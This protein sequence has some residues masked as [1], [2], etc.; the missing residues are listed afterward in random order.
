MEVEYCLTK[1]LGVNKNLLPVIR[2]I[3]VRKNARFKDIKN[4]FR[5]IA[6]EDRW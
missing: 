4:K 2:T 6:K 5:E 3:F 1:D